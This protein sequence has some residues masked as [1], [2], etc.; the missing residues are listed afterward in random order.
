[1]LFNLGQLPEAIAT[2]VDSAVAALERSLAAALD[3]RKLTAAGGGKAVP[4]A[5]APASAAKV[6]RRSLIIAA[7]LAWRGW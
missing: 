7:L 6:G 3:P 1:M 2:R 4:G 5:S